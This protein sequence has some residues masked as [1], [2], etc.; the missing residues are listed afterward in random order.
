MFVLQNGKCLGC[1]KPFANSKDTH[2]DHCHTT[3]KVRGLLCRACNMI[4]G[5]AGDNANVLR[6]LG[7]YLENASSWRA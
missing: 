5:I 2:T 7:A 1:L 6:Q 3:G 4:I